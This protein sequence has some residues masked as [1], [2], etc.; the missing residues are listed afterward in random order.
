[1]PLGDLYKEMK[2]KLKYLYDH[3]SDSVMFEPVEFFALYKAVCDL[4]Q[5]K[6]ITDGQ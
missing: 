5:I 2:I 4:M 1:M 3:N 6:H